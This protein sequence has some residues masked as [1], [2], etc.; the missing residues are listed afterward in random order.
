MVLVERTK[1]G[2]AMRATS[3]DREAAAMMGIDVD[4]VIASTFFIGSAL[5]GAAGVLVGLVFF[6]I[7]H[8]MGFTYG[9]EGLHGGGRRRHRQHP[10]RDARRARS[11]GSPRRTRSAT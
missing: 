4:R 1:L 11:S 5:A 6:Q 10:R 9:L 2:K 3:Y 8:F 7:N